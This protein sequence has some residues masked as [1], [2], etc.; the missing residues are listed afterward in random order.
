VFAWSQSR[1]N[2]PGWYGLGSALGALRGERGG[3][4]ALRQMYAG[5]PFFASTLDNA[6]LALARSDLTVA[7]AY[8]ELAGDDPDSR[9]IWSTI[10]DEHARSVEAVLEVTGRSRLLENL[11]VLR[12]SIDLRNP[13][14]DS[15][16]ELQV[17]LLAELRRTTDERERAR[18]LSL[19]ALTVN[20]VAAGLQGTG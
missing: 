9:R 18:L 15:L 5:W 3:L 17:R 20:G 10:E 7:R 11:P 2:L 1:A 12:R 16:S 8:A 13:Y 14:V 19:V 6:E 4:E